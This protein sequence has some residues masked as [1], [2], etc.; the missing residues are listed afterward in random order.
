M[1]LNDHLSF[2]IDPATDVLVAFTVQYVFI[3]GLYS[4]LPMSQTQ[5]AEA[6]N[7]VEQKYVLSRPKSDPGFCIPL[8]EIIDQYLYQKKGAIVFENEVINKKYSLGSIQRELEPI[9]CEITEKASNGTTTATAI[10]II[11]A[12]ICKLNSIEKPKYSH[13]SH[14]DPQWWNGIKSATV[15]TNIF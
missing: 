1:N 2:K 8:F 10:E 12:V 13:P 5:I 14:L 11:D 3:K 7:H 9:K 6:L 4:A 15:R